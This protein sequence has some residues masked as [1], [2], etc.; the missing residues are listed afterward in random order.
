LNEPDSSRRRFELRRLIGAGAFG[1]VYLAEQVS[2]GGF[3]RRVALK[4]LNESASRMKEAARRM[5]DEARILGRLQHKHIVEVL[6]LVQLG[7]RWA[8]V[9]AWVPG[10]D[11]EQVLGWLEAHGRPFPAPAACAVGA[12]AAR[13]LDAA[14]RAEDDG[15]RP[16][17]VVHRDIKPSNIRVTRDGE[18]KVLDFGVARVE[19]LDSREAKT[20]KPGMLGTE[21]YMAPERILLEGDGPEGDV[22]ALAATVVELLIGRPIGRSPVRDEA[23]HALVNAVIDEAAGRLTGPDEVKQ[24]LLTGL[25]SALHPLPAPRPTADDL[26]ELFSQAA[27][28]LEGTSLEAFCAEVIPRAAEATD[29]APS[30]EL[31]QRTLIEGSTGGRSEPPPPAPR[32][33]GFVAAG[34]ALTGLALGL[35][36]WWS[37]P[38]APPEVGAAVPPPIEGDATPTTIRGGA[39]APPTTSEGAT[40]P[41]TS[42]GAAPPTTIDGGATPTT[43]ERGAPPGAG[44]ATPPL[45]AR[46]SA[47]TD[48]NRA[49]PA[50]ERATPA[51]RTPAGEPPRPNA[52]PAPPPPEA[53]AAP[54]APEPPAEPAARVSRI[55]VV[56][57]D[58]S[59]FSVRCGDRSAEGTASARV[60]DLPAG[61][62]TI[63]ASREGQSWSTSVEVSAPRELRCAVQGD[64][65]S[66]R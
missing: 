10:A 8:I 2:T 36:A 31:M 6:D 38:A 58:V 23:H 66:C 37:L 53:P 25:R 43:I 28:H 3:K 42:D 27:R 57:D 21:R 44:G 39:L 18:I 60:V 35:A 7:D 13:A 51:L 15:G 22:Y 62:C 48:P 5:R 20:R 41:T 19:E 49:A 12:A 40:P 24:A 26:A 55:L 32:Y 46:A 16:L 50:A 59:A 64:K 34:L 65:L 29:A 54:T 61:P 56:V 47:S 30:S 4:L 14:W 33:L 9:M 11:L 17:R 45:G 1:E 52:A 63:R